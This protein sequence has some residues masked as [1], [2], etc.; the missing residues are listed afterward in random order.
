MLLSL[1]VRLS[2]KLVMGAIIIAII[3][4]ATSPARIFTRTQSLM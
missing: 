3:V 1:S 4:T 2:I